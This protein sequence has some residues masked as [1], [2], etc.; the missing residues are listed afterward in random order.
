MLGKEGR[1]AYITAILSAKNI[2]VK[3]APVIAETLEKAYFDEEYGCMTI[4]LNTSMKKRIASKV[5]LKSP[6]PVGSALG[7]LV[8][9]GLAKM[10]DNGMYVYNPAYFGSQHWKNMEAVKISNIFNDAGSSVEIEASYNGVFVALNE[11]NFQA[12]DIANEE[13]NEEDDETRS[14]GF[15]PEPVSPEE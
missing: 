7:C 10:V 13:T 12:L 8:D 9:V 4:M 5:G 3:H 6:G 15:M 14:D 11:E 1:L 2:P